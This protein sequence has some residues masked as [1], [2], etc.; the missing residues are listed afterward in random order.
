[1]VVYQASL[2]TTSVLLHSTRTK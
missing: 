1:M 2:K